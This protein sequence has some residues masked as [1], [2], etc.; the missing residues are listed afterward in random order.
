METHADGNRNVARP[1]IVGR[2]T[3]SADAGRDRI[4]RAGEGDEEGIA[5]RIH[6]RAAALG[7]RSAKQTAMRSE[8]LPIALLQPLYQLRRAVDVG[9]EERDG[10]GGQRHCATH[11]PILTVCWLWERK[12]AAVNDTRYVELCPLAASDTNSERMPLR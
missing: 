10:S 7:E 5:L 2:R 4:G 9:E 12:V 3:L 1:G 11:L 8:H 6:L